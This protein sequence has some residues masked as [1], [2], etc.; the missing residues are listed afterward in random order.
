MQDGKES[1][2]YKGFIHER[3]QKY[4]MFGLVKSFSYPRK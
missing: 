2:Y 3:G 4:F 1:F